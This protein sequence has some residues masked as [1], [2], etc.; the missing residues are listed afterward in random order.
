M[1]K[2][3]KSYSS[4]NL[5]ILCST[6][7]ITL[8]IW[9]YAK[10]ADEFGIN[11]RQEPSQFEAK[12]PS[13]VI[14]PAPAA[15][16]T[17]VV[18]ALF[19]EERY[20]LHVRNYL[21]LSSG[22]LR[23]QQLVPFLVNTSS[24]KPIYVVQVGANTGY[25]LKTT[26]LSLGDPAVAAV[27]NAAARGVLIEPVPANFAE[28][29]EN[30][31]PFADRFKCLN[32]A[33]NTGD[34]A[35]SRMVF[36]AMD[37]VRVRKEWPSAFQWFL[38]QIGSFDIN[39]LKKHFSHVEMHWKPKYPQ[40]YYISRTVVDAVPPRSIIEKLFQ[41]FPQARKEDEVISLLHVDAE[42][43]DWKI[44]HAFLKNT[45]PR[46]IVFERKHLSQAEIALSVEVME[47]LGYEHWLSE[48]NSFAIRRALNSSRVG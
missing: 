47:K 29:T 3:I 42:G 6:F 21:S 27:K 17:P 8:Y 15:H 13:P 38:N 22:K 14:P 9:K 37:A 41:H 10:P 7:L 26:T 36:Y 48:E 25:E 20:A 1:L 45:L 19:T 28:L 44:M 18:P 30:L 16:G 33:V 39:H 23:V 35:A 24:P 31:R 32:V 12:P 2:H 34:R 4:I 46:A 40:D 11:P 43:F 5:L